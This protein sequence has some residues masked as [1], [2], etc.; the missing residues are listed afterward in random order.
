LE[1][2][3]IQ[4]TELSTL[5]ETF[6]KLKKLKRATLSDNKLNFLLETFG[7][8]ESLILLE[9]DG[10]KI[11]DLPETFGNLKNLKRISLELMGNKSFYDSI[12][13]LEDIS[14]VEIKVRN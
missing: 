9:I 2:L 8:L 13:R 11:T 3:R 4:Q 7:D 6:G 10:N 14:A 5:P 1:D 12:I